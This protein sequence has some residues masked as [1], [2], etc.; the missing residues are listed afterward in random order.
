M[1][2]SAYIISG[3]NMKNNKI[4]DNHKECIREIED[5]FDFEFYKVLFEPIRSEIFKY[6]SVY[7]PQNIGEIA[8]NFSQDRSVISR[9]L[10][11]M[12]KQGI[13]FKKKESR[14]VV[15]EVDCNKVQEKFQQT[16]GKLKDLINNCD[17]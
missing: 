14:F 2:V 9:H 17:I 8:E 1:H 6:L 5:I 11:V 4:N 16:S 12:Y 3:E 15:Y 13:L 7:G 10:D